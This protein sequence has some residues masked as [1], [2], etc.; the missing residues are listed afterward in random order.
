M[1]ANILP[2]DLDNTSIEQQRESLVN[3]GKQPTT[4]WIVA[5]SGGKDSVA[6]VLHILFDL[7]IPKSQVELWHHDVDGGGANLWDWVCTPDYCKAF[8]KAF[9]LPILFSWRV[10]GITREIYR[11]DEHIQNVQYENIDGEVITLQSDTKRATSTRGKFPGVNK[12]LTIRWCSATVKI[13]VM[14]RVITNDAR[15][16]NSNVIIC[17]GERRAESVAR[18][19]YK[20]VELYPATTKKRTAYT[21]RTIIDWSDEQVWDIMRRHNVQPHPAYVL[22]WGRCSC[23]TC[24]FNGKDVW[25]T[26]AE[27]SPEKIDAIEGI[28]SDIKFTLY[29]KTPIREK[30]NQGTSFL[31]LLPQDRAAYWVRQATVEYNA[32]I[33]IDNWELPLGANSTESAGAN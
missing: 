24:I 17:T 33:I 16:K 31:A 1:S 6:M 12:D 19:K 8:A 21:Y 2:I 32:P 5:F 7:N 28:E 9:D 4:K 30:A 29:D 13:M 3:F 23:Q 26:I 27:I 25:A 10:G 22:G 20:E 14:S 11:N 18:S 15:F